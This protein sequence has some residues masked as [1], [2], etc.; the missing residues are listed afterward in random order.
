MPWIGHHWHSMRILT[1]IQLTC[2]G[3]ECL[4]VLSVLCAVAH[5]VHY[6]AAATDACIL[7]T[8]RTNR[9]IDLVSDSHRLFVLL[10]WIVQEVVAAWVRHDSRRLAIDTMSLYSRM[11]TSL[12][13]QQ[14]ACMTVAVG[15]NKI[16]PWCSPLTNPRDQSWPK[17]VQCEKLCLCKSVWGNTV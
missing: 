8:Q 16:G 9:C 10:A 1:Q 4:V 2:L 11:L 5:L 15:L 13:Q 7:F 14:L 17:E 3:C 12:M 6:V